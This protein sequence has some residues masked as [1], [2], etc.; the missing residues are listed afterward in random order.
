M[1]KTGT[2]RI[3]T[4]KTE[5]KIIA[6]RNANEAQFK[7]QA[8]VRNKNRG[9]F[10]KMFGIGKKSGKDIATEEAWRVSELVDKTIKSEQEALPK[11]IEEE[12]S[13]MSE[14]DKKYSV[15][16]DRILK[17]SEFDKKDTATIEAEE[18]LRSKDSDIAAAIKNNEIDQAS[19]HFRVALGKIK[20][21]RERSKLE[22]EFYKM[23]TDQFDNLIK[24]N[25]IPG[26]KTIILDNK[27][28]SVG[29]S[30]IS[31]IPQEII[32]ST[33]IQAKFI[34]QIRS[35]FADGYYPEGT[36]RMVQ[37]FIKFKLIT[38]E[39]V[40]DFFNSPEMHKIMTNKI[41]SDF[42]DGYSPEKAAQTAQDFIKFK[43]ITLEQVT[44][45]FN[46]P[47]MQKILICR[48]RDTVTNGYSSEIVARQVQNFIKLGFMTE[49]A[50]KQAL[51]TLSVIKK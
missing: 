44:D 23:I 41:R 25:D 26:I 33:E 24:A 32:N 2:P 17:S 48:I 4:Q 45:F 31:K 39:Q 3:N 16:S 22:N 14:S 46:T 49:A 9:L 10:E 40:T 12:A 7:E 28:T 5:K 43:F 18:F 8:N 15:V 13:L 42:A 1:E 19:A 34:S 51:D 29:L 35:N 36:A 11:T 21:R 30:N 47:E 6:E 50:A 38:L 37:D 27:L 20:D